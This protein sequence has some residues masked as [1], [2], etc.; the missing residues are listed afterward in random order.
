MI[1]I[2]RRKYHKGNKNEL[3]HLYSTQIALSL[4]LKIYTPRIKPK[5]K[6]QP[7]INWGCSSIPWLRSGILFNHPWSVSCAINKIATLRLFEDYNIN[8][9]QWTLQPELAEMFF[10]NNSKA[11]VFCRTKINGSGGSGIV[12]A[13]NPDELVEAGLYTLYIPKMWEYRVH[14][15]SGNVIHIQQKK[16]KA[17]IDNQL[18]RCHGNG[19]YFSTNLK[20]DL[21]SD[22][23]Q[24]VVGI[25]VRS[26]S[27]L[28]LDFGAVDVIVTKEGEVYALEV[29]TSPGL[30]G[31][32]VQ[33]YIDAFKIHYL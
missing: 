8:T 17:G 27:S 33:K 13:R 20:H 9:V 28:G 26:V 1:F 24:A 6:M 11:I 23:Y 29:N 22:I 12:I 18:V 3:S 19:Y 31:N 14:V 32:T 21:D 7:M 25:G 16:R 4:G 10:D 2:Q 5:D 15:V 30:E